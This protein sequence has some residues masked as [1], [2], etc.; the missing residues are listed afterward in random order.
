LLSL[1][2]HRGEERV[3]GKGEDDDEEK[4]GWKRKRERKALDTK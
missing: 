3:K 2:P 4:K 1:T